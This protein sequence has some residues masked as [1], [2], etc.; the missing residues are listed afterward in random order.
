MRGKK[1]KADPKAKAQER[2]PRQKTTSKKARTQTA[3][4][5]KAPTKNAKRK[6]PSSTNTKHKKRAK[7]EMQ[8]PTRRSLRRKEPANYCDADD[9]DFE[10]EAFLVDS[11]AGTDR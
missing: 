6:Q 11:D 3:R 8:S 5:K 9:L 10:Q 1:K 7:G 4:T 2:V